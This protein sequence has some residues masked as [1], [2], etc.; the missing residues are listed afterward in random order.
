[1]KGIL[2]FDDWSVEVVQLRLRKTTKHGNPYTGICNITF[3][4]GEAHIEG[5]LCEDF[6]RKDHRTI[7]RIC[8]AFGYPKYTMKRG[9]A[10]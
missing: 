7:R 9:E 3:V 10:L 1:M 2:Q 4:N 6:T 8:K 5:L